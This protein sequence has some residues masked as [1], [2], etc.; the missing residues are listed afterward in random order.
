MFDHADELEVR[1]PTSCGR[2]GFCHECIV[3]VLRG[4]ESL[5]ER[6]EEEAFLAENYRLACQATVQEEA[7]NI[8]FALLRRSPQILTPGKSIV[9][10]F[11]P[12]LH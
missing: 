4:S 1:V 11:D 10:N 6:T 7:T 8:E 12:H 5:S 9:E 3:E 2:T